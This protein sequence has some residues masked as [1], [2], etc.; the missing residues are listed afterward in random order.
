MLRQIGTIKVDKA[1]RRHRFVREASRLLKAMEGCDSNEPVVGTENDNGPMLQLYGWRSCVPKHVDNTGISYFSPVCLPRG[2]SLVSAICEGRKE[3][4]VFLEVGGVYELDDHFSH[5]TY[6]KGPVVC[7]FW[8]PV[9]KPDP[10]RALKELQRGQALLAD[11]STWD[12]PRISPG[13]RIYPLHGECVAA[14]INGMVE[15]M[16]ICEAKKRGWLIARCAHQGCNRIAFNVDHHYP[17]S[18]E[19]NRCLRHFG[20]DKA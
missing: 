14:Q 20:G 6:E 3:E 16:R 4:T 7:M 12:A 18:E 1:V 11:H 15:M 8:G 5:Y 9:I 13:F 2:G 10:A 19:E 17:Y